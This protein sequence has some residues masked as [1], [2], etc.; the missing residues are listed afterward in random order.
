MGIV[1]FF[2]RTRVPGKILTVVLILAGATSALTIRREFFPDIE[3]D[4]A[5]IVLIYPGATGQE[6][7]DSLAR[8][9]EDIAVELD[10]VDRIETTISDGGGAIIVRFDD[11]TDMREKLDDLRDRTEALAD[12][13]LEAERIQ[14]VELEATIPVIQVT[15]FGDG[16]SHLLKSAIRQVADDLRTFDGMGQVVTSGT[17]DEELRIEVDHG[18]LLRHGI[19]ITRVVDAVSAWMRKTPGGTVRS[20]D[21]ET[22]VRTLG[23]DHRAEQI[24][25][26][27]IK[28]FPDGGLITVEDVA[29]VEEGFV[30]DVVVR[31]FNGSPAANCTVFRLS[32][33]DSI[34]IAL[35]TRGYVAARRGEPLEPSV[36]E[37]FV[38]GPRVEGWT[39]GAS[40]GS[41]AVGIAK[42]ND[43]AKLIEGRLDLLISN[44]IQG[45]LLVFFALLLGVH[46]RAACFVTLGIVV[47][48]FGTIWAMD[49]TGISLNML[50]M[51]ALLLSIGIQA[52]DAI[53][54]SE[55]VESET[56]DQSVSVEDGVVRGVQ[57]I[58]W[59]V[60]ASAATTVV[61]FFPLGLVKGSVG[62]LLGNLPLVVALALGISLFEA[63]FLMPSHMAGAIRREREGRRGFIDRLMAPVDRWREHRLW[64]SVE[65]WYRR[66]VLWCVD[67]RYMT[68]AAGISTFIVSLG[69][70]AGGRLPFTFLPSDDSET[71]VIDIRLPLGSSLE[72]TKALGARV[73]EVARA[74]AETR[75]VTSLYG[76]SVNLDTAL[77]DRSS[78]N[79]AQMFVELAP[80]ETRD[81]RSSEVIDSIVKV[82]QSL[83]GAESIRVREFTGGPTGSDI[84]YELSGPD[85]ARL[86]EVAES[87]KSTLATVQ[88]VMNVSDDDFDAAPEVQVEVHPSAAALGLTPSDV[89]RQVRGAIFGLDAHVFSADREE[90]DVRVRIDDAARA[91]SDIADRMWVVSPSGV[92][93]PLGEIATIHERTA[94]ST[95]RRLDRLRT[96]TVTADTEEATHPESV[97]EKIT[98]A[99]SA[100]MQSN[101]EM[102][103]RV[104]G[105]QQD[106]NDAFASLPIAMLAAVLMIYAILAW[107]FDSMTQPLAVMVSI[108]FG[109]IGMVAG[110]LLMGYDLTF[111][112]LIGL[113]ALAGVVVNNA[114]VLVEFINMEVAAG[115]PLREALAVAGQKRIRAILL[116]SVTGVLGLAPLVLAQSFQARFLAPMALT[117][118]A[119][120]VS[121]TALTLILLPS[122]MHIIDDTKRLA[123]RVWNGPGSSAQVP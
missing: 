38:G 30:D 95:I 102:R 34:D 23:V 14:V 114:L 68:V 46:W 11:G 63:T 58:A 89:A 13:P 52:D 31:T 53:V 28:A 9:V 3:T 26:I 122:L 16:N 18:A 99:I 82:A 93:V 24:R 42:H 94:P 111:L 123:E 54:F 97:V 51:F 10:G 91:D 103:I 20:A 69:L 110:H 85:L 75:A 57:K 49:M 35:F 7:E 21:S 12:L 64:P 40:R 70:I 19:P 105:R 121:A 61:A 2:I 76:V 72:A 32:G 47:A 104:G 120:L 87:I 43:L 84:T 83:E 6:I 107:L 37:R 101:P 36:V 86:R 116:T 33:Q 79:L 98:P 66:A 60:V 41:M 90:V 106:L 112:S 73:E 25:A 50:T 81:R 55:S 65:R 45:G 15:V 109:V 77:A 5:R 1:R 48:V 117:L 29:K 71:F 67:R 88:G 96:I 44:A 22:K 100:L 118:S 92:T 8:R 108:P 119:G 113:I 27:V 80:V 78:S 39:L 62:D 74:Q 56:A 59:P 115:R 17:R 4:A